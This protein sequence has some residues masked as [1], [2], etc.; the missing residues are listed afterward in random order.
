MQGVV[1]VY[2][3][4]SNL[5]IS[6][7]TV[8]S[9]LRP[10]SECKT[11]GTDLQPPAPSPPPRPLLCPPNHEGGRPPSTWL[12][13][14]RLSGSTCFPAQIL[15]EDRVHP[16]LFSPLENQQRAI[17]AIGAMMVLDGPFLVAQ[18]SQLLH[19]C[20]TSW[21]HPTQQ[22]RSRTLCRVLEMPTCPDIGVSCSW[23]SASS[24]SFF[25]SSSCHTCR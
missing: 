7:K 24:L 19:H 15:V 5:H 14:R 18:T 10:W 12:S 21:W 8:D 6:A 13:S 2:W 20:C 25:G 11:R 22:Y 1:V 9:K 3:M 16:W 4:P 23:C 17:G